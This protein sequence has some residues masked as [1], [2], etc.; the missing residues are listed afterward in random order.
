MELINFD[1]LGASLR[2]FFRDGWVMHGWDDERDV[3]YELWSVGKGL[4]LW[5][6]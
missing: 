3:N 1:I 2:G 5:G 4:Y 6:L